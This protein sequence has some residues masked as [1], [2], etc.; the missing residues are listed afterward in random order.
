MGMKP[1]RFVEKYISNRREKMDGAEPLPDVGE[2][3]GVV[4]DCREGTWGKSKR[5]VEQKWLE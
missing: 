5:E 1:D 3:A 4:V 2:H